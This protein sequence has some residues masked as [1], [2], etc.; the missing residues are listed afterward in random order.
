MN[1]SLRQLLCLA[2]LACGSAMAETKPKISQ[3]WQF[4]PG[5]G[6]RSEGPA[7]YPFHPDPQ[8]DYKTPYT[9][10]LLFNG[11]DMG[12]IFRSENGG[13]SWILIDSRQVSHIKARYRSGFS[14]GPTRADAIYVTTRRGL[15]KS[16]DL[17]ISWQK[18]EGP[19]AALGYQEG[20]DFISLGRTKSGFLVAG[21]KTDEEM[22]TT[23]KLYKSFTANAPKPT[24]TEMPVPAGCLTPLNFA[25]PGHTNHESWVM[26]LGCR[27]GI[28]LSKDGGANW[29]PQKQGL[30]AAP[31]VDFTFGKPNDRTSI[32]FALTEC[33][34][35]T[36]ASPLF[37]ALNL[38]IDEGVVW[39]Q[40]GS[41]G[42]GSEHPSSKFR[43]YAQIALSPATPSVVYL[44][45][46]ETH[47][48]VIGRD[49]IGPHDEGRGQV[50][51]SRDTGKTWK[52]IFHRHPDHPEFSLAG[53]QGWR[54]VGGWGWRLGPD[55][56]AIH[57]AYP[58]IVFVSDM[59][60]YD[61]GATWSPTDTQPYLPAVQ[62]NPQVPRGGFPIM[63]YSDFLFVPNSPAGTDV[64][65]LAATDF[66]GWRTVNG[67]A[68]WEFTPHHGEVDYDRAGKDGSNNV[69]SVAVERGRRSRIWAAG[70]WGHNVPTWSQLVP[71]YKK[72]PSHLGYSDDFGAT[73]TKV[74]LPET[75][76]AVTSVYVDETVRN[77]QGNPAVRAAILNKGYYVSMD[78]GATWAK[79]EIVQSGMSYKLGR[80]HRG[81]RYV[82]STV[83][84]NREYSPGDLLVQVPS[85][86]DPKKLEWVKK[87]DTT[88]I[89]Y[90]INVTFVPASPAQKQPDS[91][92][93]AAYSTAEYEPVPN[94]TTKPQKL[95]GVFRSDDDGASWRRLG[96][97]ELTAPVYDVTV[98][99]KNRKC[100]VASVQGKGLYLSVNEGQTWSRVESFPPSFPWRLKW[101]TRPPTKERPWL[102]DHLVVTTFGQGL[103]SLLLT[104]P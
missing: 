85:K 17:G 92:Y 18:V 6:G 30:P 83:R 3:V 77:A 34:P 16:H 27:E 96:G 44:T 81:R 54:S 69:Y 101:D 74:V 38:S 100:V 91:I 67:A 52:P 88:E 78:D 87:G 40:S 64:Q 32:L 46:H 24:W 50:F 19:W 104:C 102:S 2:V 9:P 37:Y 58:E 7:I 66:G 76:G 84:P 60:S 70:A 33:A 59:I 98:H 39:K 89:P 72:F 61:F 11:S 82:L 22:K 4:G 8:F 35:P 25:S 63:G 57:P 47:V 95:G 56:I 15:M 53:K 36:C 51:V 23:V 43:K 90:P 94:Q 79:E 13:R 75:I 20:P 55:G 10:Q 65:I 28:F 71:G 93:L 1:I 97:A 62:G 45:L 14:F 31:I 86:K 68:S 99:P 29:T 42:L 49:N 12:T 103:W 73:W 80:D 41:V 21:Y 26:A 48:D 5:G